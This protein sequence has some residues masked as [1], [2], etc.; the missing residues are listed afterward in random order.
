M[1]G[2]NLFL[3][4][5]FDKSFKILCSIELNPSNKLGIVILFLLLCHGIN[6]QS[7]STK[8][9]ILVV[10]AEFLNFETF[11]NLEHQYLRTDV[12]IRHKNTYLFCDSAIIVGLKVRA[13][14]H[15]RI[16]ETDSLQIFGDTLNYDGSTLKAELINNVSLIHHDKQLFTQKL[17]YDLK[18][19]I[20]SYESN[21]VLISSDTR[22]KSKKGFYFAKTEKS[23][24]KDSVNIL[25]NN[26][27]NVQT[28]TIE[29][30]AKA[31]K[32]YFIAPT[33]IKRDSLHIYCEK[34]FYDITEQKTYLD[35]YPIYRNRNEKADARIIISD[36][37]K[38]ITTLFENARISDSVSLTTGDTIIVN[39]SLHTISI[40][41]HG[42][43][44]DKERE[45]QGDKIFYNR[46]DKSIQVEGKTEVSEG[47]QKIKADKIDY[48]G[49]DDIGYA[50]GNVVIRDTLS[51]WEIH[52]DT[53]SYNKRTKQFF[54]IGT[55]KYIATPFDNDTLYLSSQ[56]LYSQQVI[57]GVDTFQIMVAD[58]NV[59]IW[60]KKVRGLC[61]SLYFNGKDSVFT[62]FYNPVLWSDSTQFTGD[63]ILLYM[64]HKIL[65]RI[66][67]LQKAF[68]LTESRNS[69]IDQIKG[70]NI[71]AYFVDKKINYV[72]ILGNAEAI[73]YVSEEG[74]GYIGMNYIKCSKMQIDF[75]EDQK[76]DK[77]HFYTKPEGNMIPVY[78]GKDKR[79][80][81]FNQRT[82]EQPK[83]FEELFIAIYEN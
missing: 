4:R 51:S 25:L 8:N 40:Y 9:K 44:H 71:F 18:N 17:N 74:K 48:K 56:I 63:T 46:R 68:I 69:L 12:V 16:V 43:Y 14:G 70:R 54:P 50:F 13:L 75:F 2:I 53:S 78:Q 81:G 65:D 33:T 38:K 36:E 23:Y 30:D 73:Y 58:K 5:M 72:D 27:M 45:I 47:P 57:E 34:G 19:R 76:I 11:N 22:M 7:D 42:I 60:S 61:D 32:V 80:E 1:K 82:Q 10:H 41:G 6:A 62:L 20:A 67:L 3:H 21:G 24:F 26:G 29:M 66:H 35:Q 59:R 28:D 31:N 15:V 55:R 52:C 83:N 49:N 37:R 79:L 39:D 77:I 64:K